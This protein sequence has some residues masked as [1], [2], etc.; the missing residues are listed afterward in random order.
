MSVRPMRAIVIGAGFGGLAAAIRLQSKG[1]ATTVLEKRDKPGGRAYVFEDE[2]FTF[3]AGPTVITAPECL[4]ELFAEAGRPMAAYVDLLP[5]QPFYRLCWEDGYRFDH[6]N[7]DAS[8]YSQIAAKSPADVDGYRR[9]LDYSKAVYK[10]GYEELVHVPFQ[11]F[12]DM[13][14]VSPELVRLAAYRPVYDTVARYIR[15]EQLRQ[16]FSFHSLL[17]GG[18]PF[19]ASSIYTL[20]HTLEREGGVYFPRGGTG[21]LVKGLVRLLHDLG[22]E[23]RTGAEVEEI[24]TESGRVAGVV[25]KDGRRE[26]CDLVVANADVTHTYGKLL[27]REPLVAPTARK[28]SRM[29]YSMSLFLVYVGVKRT[30]PEL[31]HHSILFGNR[32]RE[33]LADI[34]E[35]GVL[36]DDFSLY[37]HAPCRTDPSLAPE[38]CDALYALAPV[39]HLGKWRGDWRT[40]GPRYAERI[41]AYLEKHYLPGLRSHVVTQRIFTPLDFESELNAFLGSAFSLEPTLLQSAYFRAHNRDDRLAGLYFVGAGTHPG[42]GV[43]GVI[44]SAK[45]TARVIFSD[46]RERPEFGLEPEYA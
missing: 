33:L 39:P 43:P 16:A 12:W 10:A 32:Y 19:S 7:D 21:A 46:L 31:R 3:D 37:L 26:P 17:I 23:V 2:G 24:L 34:F 15:D 44:N 1:V 11:S 36:A 38:G 13:V 22:G 4:E 30:Y 42:A 28:L 27:R 9:F 40:E 8:L 5:V 18:N 6:S 41:L 25:T 29:R 45:A 35:R 20:I 14:R